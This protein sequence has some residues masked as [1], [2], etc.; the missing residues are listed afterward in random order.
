MLDQVRRFS[1]SKNGGWKTPA[2][3]YWKFIERSGFVLL[4]ER[5]V[6]LT[7]QL[8][9]TAAEVE[10][11]DSV[12]GTKVQLPRAR[13]A[14]YRGTSDDTEMSSSGADQEDLE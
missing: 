5:T 7:R 4:S 3:A 14:P 12:G 2:A 1:A 13:S 6:S 9:D 11:G 8:N 10:F